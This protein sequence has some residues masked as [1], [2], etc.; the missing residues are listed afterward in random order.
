MLTRH[1]GWIVVSDTVINIRPGVPTN[2]T[3]HGV[4]IDP[5][6]DLPVNCQKYGYDQFCSDSENKMIQRSEA[7]LTG[8]STAFFVAVDC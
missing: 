5:W 2:T 8:Q 1:I 6:M 7:F 3:T 4:Q